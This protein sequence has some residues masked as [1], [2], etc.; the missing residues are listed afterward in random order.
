[1]RA[2]I[3]LFRAFEKDAEDNRRILA[4]KGKIKLPVL[5]LG[6]TASFFLPIAEK[7]LSEAAENVTVRAVEDSGHWM[8]EEQPEQLLER[9]REWFQE[10]GG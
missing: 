8:A 5:G 7:M 4:E 6:G 2:G 9:L 3:E 10:T 1:M